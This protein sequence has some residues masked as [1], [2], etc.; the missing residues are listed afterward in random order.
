MEEENFIVTKESKAKGTSSSVAA[1]SSGA[2]G[3]GDGKTLQERFEEFRREKVRQHLIEERRAQ[4]ALEIRR[5][6]ESMDALREKFVQQ[7]LS[8]VGIPYAQRYHQPGSPTHDAP[9]FLDCCALVRRSVN[10]LEDEFGF[11]L[12]RWNQAYQFD[13]LPTVIEDPKDMK[14]GDLIF[15]EATYY[16]EKLKP[17]IHDIVHVEI[18]LEG[19][20][21]VGARYQKGFVQIH[22]SY[23]FQSKNYYNIKYHFRS[24]DTWLEGICRSHCADHPWQL[25]VIT[26]GSKSI[27]SATEEDIARLE[28][29]QAEP[30]GLEIEDEEFATSPVKRVLEPRFEEEAS[31]EEASGKDPSPSAN[32]EDVK[33]ISP[34]FDFCKGKTFFA[35]P[36]NG[37]EMVVGTLE[38]LGMKRVMDKSVSTF[39]F[40]WVECKPD[41]DY[42]RFKEGVQLVNHISNS[43]VLVTKI[44]LMQSLRDYVRTMSMRT[45][46]GRVSE[47]SAD[48]RTGSS[49]SLDDEKM[50]E[51]LKDMAFFP[52]SYRLDAADERKAFI[53]RANALEEK[54]TVWIIKPNGAN[55]GKGIT[56][57]QGPAA[58]E[59]EIRAHGTNRLA[60][61]YIRNPLL[62]NG[63]KFDVRIYMLI[64]STRPFVLMYHEGYVRISAEEYTDSDFENVIMHLT[65]AAVQRKGSRFR[66]VKEDLTW[67]FDGLQTYLTE[68]NLAPPSWVTDTFV[69]QVQRIMRT[70][71]ESVRHR[72]E[73]KAGFFDL[74][75]CDFMIDENLKVWLIEMNTNPAIMQT[76]PILK[77]LLPPMIDETIR[78]VLEIWYK[79]KM[80]KKILPVESMK[81]FVLL[82]ADH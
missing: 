10:D 71:F 47:S 34:F 2:D 27:F 37:S 35:V 64:G 66:E 82:H 20:K 62:L 11:R 67:T 29:Q 40:R 12:G 43:Q 49:S 53:K 50:I 38:S 1:T 56:I 77:E 13:T 7:A 51:P 81:E 41:I 48:T 21:T 59:E 57:V 68:K 52:E 4:Q 39:F 45:R 44:G 54:E 32:R 69:P 26:P 16:N 3:A 60:Q 36:R 22:D 80:R 23:Q 73:R 75:G 14:R 28:M 15:Y 70:A 9:L 72:L 18:F 8:Y 76:C 58:V 30:Q 17:Q 61:R 33:D 6:K 78:I 63:R 5:T 25:P 19:E 65:N 55:Q 46:A 24:I 79:A 74:I 31:L 42:R